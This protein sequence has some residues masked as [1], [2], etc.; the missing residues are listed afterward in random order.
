[1]NPPN[2]GENPSPLHDD[3]AGPDDS[4]IRRARDQVERAA[5]PSDSTES[6]RASDY[7]DAR[8][9][10]SLDLPPDMLPGY[11]LI[12]KI[13]RGGQGVVYQAIQVATKR[14]VAIKVIGEGPSAEPAAKERFKREIEL[15]ATLDHPNIVKIL[16][17]G[18]AGGHY[19]YAMD[20]IRGEPFDHY[21][22]NSNLS[23]ERLIAAFTKTCDAVDY[24]H[25]RGIIHRDLKPSNILVDQRG[26]P[27]VLDFGMAKSA[28]GDVGGEDRPILI[29]LTGQV[30]GTLPYMSPEQASGSNE[31]IDARTDIYSLGV[32]LYQLLTGAFPYNVVG[33]MREVLDNILKAVPRRPSTIRRRLDNDLETIVLKALAKEP[34][35]RYQSALEFGRDLAHFL[36]GEAIDAKRDSG[37]YILRKRVS[38]HRRTIAVAGL[39]AILI[40]AATYFGVKYFQAAAESTSNKVRVRLEQQHT[41][42]VGTRLA[43]TEVSLSEVS[44]KLGEYES[45]AA[46]ARILIQLKG[47]DSSKPEPPPD[48][49]RQMDQQATVRIAVTEPAKSLFP[50]RAK[51]K[52]DLIICSLLFEGLCERSQDGSIIVNERLCSIEATSDPLSRLV[53][54][55]SNLHWHDGS[56]LTVDD[57]VFTWEALRS[58]P[59]LG[60]QDDVKHISKVEKIDASSLL[61][62]FDDAGDYWARWLIFELIPAAHYRDYLADCAAAIESNDELPPE[63]KPIGCGPFVLEPGR[64]EELVLVQDSNLAPPH[65]PGIKRVSLQTVKSPDHL[66]LFLAG[67]LDLIVLTEEQ[68]KNDVY[69][70]AFR[71]RGEQISSL[72]NAT[73][74][75][76]RYIWWNCDAKKQSPFADRRVRRAIAHAINVHQI[77]DQVTG[78][79]GIPCAGPFPHDS[80]LFNREVRLL[81]YDPGIAARQLREAGYNCRSI[82]SD[83]GASSQ[84]ITAPKLK[85]LSFRLAFPDTSPTCKSIA[86]LVEVSLGQLGIDVRLEPLSTTKPRQQCEYLARIA[87]GEFDAILCEVEPSLEPRRWRNCF[88]TGGSQNVSQYSNDEVDALFD[89]AARAQDPSHQAEVYRRL[90]KV[91]YEDQ[92][93]MFLYHRPDL[94]AK[95]WSLRNVLFSQKGPFQFRPGALDWWVAPDRSTAA[96]M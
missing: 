90:H 14:K 29:S 87:Q 18:I 27:H 3:G 81:S 39:G 83:Q 67:E 88:G 72:Q 16:D 9:L 42:E 74:T 73:H 8:G 86:Q 64:A 15:I 92:P 7:V 41:T 34:E 45:I 1:M 76:F 25:R 91:L 44:K 19:F 49:L 52:T 80:P 78:G 58:S 48:D 85:P 95:S 84:P 75:N 36:A 22:R 2:S 62:S 82:D 93:V 46:H 17:S 53:R 55:K 11:E 71:S 6:L 94:W 26:E 28:G 70:P 51:G 24:A 60:R 21:V 35:R 57:I 37:W 23:I 47:A 50:F 63:P 30:L 32:I 61:V 89:E 59:E 33:H 10:M 12:R 77:N 68:A 69:T 66:R 79:H 38:R 4:L 40:G 65:R 31:R 13:H 96:P 54:L 56:P 20:Y 43:E 5:K